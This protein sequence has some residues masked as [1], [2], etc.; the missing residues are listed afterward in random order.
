MM[1]DSFAYTIIAVTVDAAL[2]GL[3]RD[4][5]GQADPVPLN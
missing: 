5:D 4:I 1:I 2:V 3:S